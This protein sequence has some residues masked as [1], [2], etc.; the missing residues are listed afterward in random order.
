L[1]EDQKKD[2]YGRNVKNLFL[3]IEKIIIAIKEAQ[4]KPTLSLEVMHLM[5]K[6]FVNGS[7]LI[8]NLS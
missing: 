7:H 1:F 2:N 6:F 4:G 3:Y 5:K 8:H